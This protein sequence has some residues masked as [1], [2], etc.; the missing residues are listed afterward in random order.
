MRDAICPAILL[1]IKFKIKVIT[2]THI[3]HSNEEPNNKILIR[4]TEA[5]IEYEIIIMQ[6]CYCILM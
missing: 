2:L 3:P 1:S 5:S 4:G 6:Q